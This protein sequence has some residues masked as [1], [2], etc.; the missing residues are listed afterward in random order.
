M[1]VLCLLD[2]PIMWHSNYD[3]ERYV[4]VRLNLFLFIIDTLKLTGSFYFVF[5]PDRILL[6]A[7]T[8]SVKLKKFL[9]VSMPREVRAI[10]EKLS[11]IPL[12]DCLLTMLDN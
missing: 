1:N 2:V 9:D 10:I 5:L 11:L 4:Y 7:S 3:K 8:H 6:K 12:V